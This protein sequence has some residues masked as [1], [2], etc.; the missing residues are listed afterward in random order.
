M[1]NEQD[2]NTTIKV[3]QISKNAFDAIKNFRA[4]WSKDIEGRSDVLNDTFFYH[5]KDVHLSKIK[6]IEKVPNKKL[7]Y[8]VVDNQFNF[9]KDKTEWI[10]SKLIFDISEGK[11]KTTIKFTHQGLTPKDECYDICDE[12]WTNYI[13]NSLYT[14]IS[15]GTGKP[16]PK[17][18]GGF[19]AEIVEKWKLK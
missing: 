9:T 13:N 4:W 18:G 1:L 10:G 15:T 3:E 11:G 6:L 19:N 7:L 5:Y 16:N 17:E 14:L 2:F 8:L 12:A